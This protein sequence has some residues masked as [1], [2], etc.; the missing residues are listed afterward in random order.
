M[1][2]PEGPPVCT[3]LKALPSL[4]P[5]PMVSMIS[6]RVIPMGTSTSPVF[7]I[8]PTRLKTLVP[9]LSGVPNLENQVAP[10]K[11]IAGTFA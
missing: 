11:M 10:F 9:L 2:P 3:A 6:R 5:P 8:L 1:H 7:S 4:T